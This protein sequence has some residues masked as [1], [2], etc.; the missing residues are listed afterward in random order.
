[1]TDVIHDIGFRHYDGPR[2]G[3]GWITRSLLVDTVRGVF[4]LG[5]PARAKVMPWVLIVVTALPALVVT[6]VVI[7][8]GADELPVS[9]TAYLVQVQ[10]P[11]A[12]FAALA[13]PYAVSRD[14]RFGVMSLY[15][16]RP[17]LRSDYVGARYLGLAAALWAVMALPQTL[18]LAGALLGKLPVG[19]NL[20]Q[21]AGGLLASLLLAA[22]LA[23][24]ALTVAAFTPRRGIGVA[25]II[26]ILLVA[27]GVSLTLTALAAGQGRDDLAA[28]AGVLDPFRLV[29][30][31]ASWVLGVDPAL[32]EA[33]P[34]GGGQVALFALV[35]ALVL[36]ACALLLRLR[37]R[38]AGGAL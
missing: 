4:G 36:G 2:L 7:I 24:L 6:L 23:A 26:A 1:M 22:V 9:P 28:L 15:L 16:S 20:V 38:K 27:S 3:R 33:A 8:A 21:W 13:A 29:D 34:T 32:A 17:M 18:L 19:H 5:R 37:Y 31:I 25:S 12:L 30:T 14:Q 10:V 11:I 35:Y